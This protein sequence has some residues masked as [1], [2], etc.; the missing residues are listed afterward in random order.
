MSIIQMVQEASSWSDLNAPKT[1]NDL[2]KLQRM[3]HPDINHEPGANAAFV[4]LTEL[5]NAPDY[6]LRV[7]SGVQKD[8]HIIEWTIKPGFKDRLEMVK[9]IKFD[10]SFDIFYTKV[11][12]AHLDSID[13]AYG[14]GF[15]FL[16]DCYIDGRSSIWI[17]KRLAAAIN[18]APRI[19]ANITPKTVVLNPSEHGLKLDG[20]FYSIKENERLELRPEARTMPKY[21][22]GSK[23]DKMLD[24]SQAAAMLA[25]V[26]DFTKE[27]HQLQNYFQQQERDPS[28]PSEFL[29]GIDKVALGLYGSPKFHI[30]EQPNKQS[31]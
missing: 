27:E 1:Q 30:M 11:A 17:A 31:I 10:S 9:F 7:A 21:L 12:K 5:F 26:T 16:E 13:V 14:E 3:V 18:K 29:A 20:W 19:H 6:D 4:K 25:D 28:T 15:W 23:A 24:V 2:R 8:G 22:G